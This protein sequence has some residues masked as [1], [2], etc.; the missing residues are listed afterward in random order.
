MNI[1]QNIS[2]IAQRKGITLTEIER[3]CGFSKSSMRKWADNIPSIEKIVKAADYLGASLDAI[4]YG[5][6]RNALCS[7]DE[8]Q[9]LSSYRKLSEINKAKVLERAITLSEEVNDDAAAIHSK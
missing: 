6:E 4:I 5:E 2:L 7:E 1:L 8:R 3:A 9:L